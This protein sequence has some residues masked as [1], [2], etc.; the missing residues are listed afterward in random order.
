MVEV[1]GN[2]RTARARVLDEGDEAECARSL[3]FT[4]YATRYDGD[5]VSWRQRAL[6][7][8]IDLAAS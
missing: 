1:D 4:K 3:V 7:V 6:P 8:A 2:V 5:L